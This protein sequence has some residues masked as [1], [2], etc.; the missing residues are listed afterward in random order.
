MK[1]A[2]VVL[3]YNTY[4][5]TLGFVSNLYRVAAGREFDLIVVDNHS[6]NESLDVLEKES[7][8]GSF[9]L[10]KNPVNS[11]YA[12]G[13]NIGI[14][15]AVEHGADYIIVANNDIEI[16]SFDVI[17]GMIS[18]LAE[19]NN[20][21]AVSPRIIGSKGEKDPPIYFK[22]PS[23]ID[24]SF[25]ILSF[26]RKRFSF[27]DS[28]TTK[29]YAPRGSFMV[30]RSTSIRD[31]GFLDEKTFLY[32]EEPILAERMLSVGLECWH[33][34]AGYVIHNHGATINSTTN[35]AS[36][37]K[38][39]LKSQ[40]YYLTHYRHMGVL[41]TFICSLYKKIGFYRKNRKK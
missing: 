22:K 33:Y 24:L 6:S 31:V 16:V 15:Y 41:K 23:F 18:L 26:N 25:G 17:D 2:F 38:T 27:D 13:N 28:L 12:A 32:Y 21:G 34:G 30:L 3:N 8:S 37:C 5:L 4:R 11:G 36:I 20:I 10:L 7:C 14:K 9:V 29:I 19:N 35:R 40:K 1:V 39:L